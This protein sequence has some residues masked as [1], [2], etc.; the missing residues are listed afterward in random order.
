MDVVKGHNGN[1][2]IYYRIEFYDDTNYYVIRDTILDSNTDRCDENYCH[3]G[4]ILRDNNNYKTYLKTESYNLEEEYDSVVLD[5]TGETEYNWRVVAEN[6][7]DNITD[8]QP[9]VSTQNED[10]FYIDLD[11]PI[12]EFYFTLNQIYYFS[13]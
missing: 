8:V 12:G 2:K 13:T 9:Y 4:A 1:T 3:I 5:V 6:Y 7:S 11:Y 10:E